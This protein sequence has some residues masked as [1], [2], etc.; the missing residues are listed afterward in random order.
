MFPLPPELAE[1][2]VSFLQKDDLRTLVQ[3]SRGLR[4]LC[5]A[6]LLSTHGISI[7]QIRS[8]A[9]TVAPGSEFL[10]PAIYRS[11]P[12]QQL[13]VHS[14]GHLALIVSILATIPPIPDIRIWG[15]RFGQK[16][17]VARLLANLSREGRDPIIL[18]GKST[19]KLSL[20][21][22]MPLPRDSGIAPR[23]MWSS[24]NGR[25]AL[26]VFK[27]M[28]GRPGDPAE[29]IEED[30]G[31]TYTPSLRVQ[32]IRIPGVAP[33]TLATFPDLMFLQIPRLPDLSSAQGTALLAA[34]DLKHQ[35]VSLTIDAHCALDFSALM[36]FI[37]RHESL[38]QLVLEPGAL[39]PASLALDAAPA[40]YQA[41]LAFL[42]APPAYIPY[43]LPIERRVENLTIAL[44]DHDTADSAQLARALAA[45]PA[46]TNSVPIRNLMLCLGDRA[47]SLLWREPERSGFEAELPL[48]GVLSLIVVVEFK[49]SP[50]VDAGALPRWLA[51]RFPDLTRLEIRGGSIPVFHQDAIAE[52]V[53][54]TRSET[55]PGV[56]FS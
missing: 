48:R 22:A 14:K 46:R 40:R 2:I 27:R 33:F 56:R 31:H 35:T 52:A 20:P 19:L 23:Q 16:P 47:S 15:L 30:L 53:A 9:I 44:D 54:E 37:H 10:I 43:L 29:R 39:D 32:L 28:F 18:A 55:W 42:S 3:V 11:H 49:Y 5:F 12:I 21:R 41:H 38:R 17:A 45:I 26:L 36:D 8:G 51:R 13:T 24:S 4:R 25:R 6:P 7:Q 1:L 50:A 34:L